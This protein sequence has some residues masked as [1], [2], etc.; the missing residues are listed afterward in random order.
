MIERT[1]MTRRA[2]SRTLST[3]QRTVTW[4]PAPTATSRK[5]TRA[6]RT[7]SAQHVKTRWVYV[8]G[9][10]AKNGKLRK[11]QCIFYVPLL[12]IP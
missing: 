4:S 8:R 6:G 1:R 10:R 3:M 9:G 12:Y 11:N 5:W 7:S 2:A